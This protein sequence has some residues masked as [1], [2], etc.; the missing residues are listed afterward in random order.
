MMRESKHPS[1]AAP[2]LPEQAM[3]EALAGFVEA[4]GLLPPEA[5]RNPDSW[6]ALS[7]T[8][9]LQPLTGNLARIAL[10]SERWE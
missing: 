3:D 2:E 10:L 1:A 5:L 9:T 8:D 4:M 7:D 6:L